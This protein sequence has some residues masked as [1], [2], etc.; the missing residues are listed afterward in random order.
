MYVS[1]KDDSELHEDFIY[2]LDCLE[3]IHQLPVGALS[4]VHQQSV[5]FDK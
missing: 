3:M 4:A 2:L 1:D 5:S